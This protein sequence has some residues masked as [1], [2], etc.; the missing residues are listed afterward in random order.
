MQTSPKVI[1]THPSGAPLESLLVKP[2]GPRSTSP[3]VN[4][5]LQY[6]L[7]Q[8]HQGRDIPGY[9]VPDD[10]EVNPEV[11]MDN[12]VAIPAHIVPGQF[13]VTH[14]DLE[15]HPAGGFSNN[16]QVEEDCFNQQAVAGEY[17]IVQA[18]DMPIYSLGR[19]QNSWMRIRQS[20]W[21]NNGLGQNLVPH[22]GPE[23]VQSGQVHRVSQEVSQVTLEARELK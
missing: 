14:L 11:L 7:Q 12:D 15:R 16:Y 18:L 6:C 5:G 1:Q 2:S 13:R 19:I 23:G 4:F 21:R 17:F 9:G 20:L 22:L 10:V 8:G 3:S